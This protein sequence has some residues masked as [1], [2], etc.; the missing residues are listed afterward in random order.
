MVSVPALPCIWG[1]IDRA[2]WKRLSRRMAVTSSR[3]MTL[4]P[5]SVRASQCWER[6]S[7]MAERTET[8]HADGVQVWQFEVGGQLC[9]HVYPLGPVSLLVLS[10]P[11]RAG[12]CLRQEG[13]EPRLRNEMGRAGRPP[14]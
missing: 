4:K 10:L 14:G 8:L 9:R 12:C 5:M 7:S 2:E 1:R 6:A 13:Q 3:R 11:L